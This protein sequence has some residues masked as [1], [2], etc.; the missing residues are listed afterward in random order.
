MGVSLARARPAGWRAEQGRPRCWWPWRRRRRG[1]PSGRRCRG[2]PARPARPP[3]P[4]PAR[5]PPRPRRAPAE[6]STVAVPAYGVEATRPP[7]P[8]RAPPPRPAGSARTTPSAPGTPRRST[9]RRVRI[10]R[11]RP[12]VPGDRVHDVPED[13]DDGGDEDDREDPQ[14]G[15]GTARPPDR[16]HRR[17]APVGRC[18]RRNRRRR[19]RASEASTSSTTDP[20]TTRAHA[21]STGSASSLQSRP[22]RRLDG[23]RGGRE[24]PD[25][26][27]GAQH[28]VAGVR[29]PPASHGPHPTATGPAVR[30]SGSVTVAPQSARRACTRPPDS[31]VS[32]STVPGRPV[33]GGVG[34]RWAE[35][36]RSG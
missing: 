25:D 30:L 3:P 9:V 16:R 20:A 10:D 35:R 34:D 21:T 12:D 2:R 8:R 19:D 13:G 26:R 22:C 17:S 31:T 27:D 1:S 36:V 15:G 18:R 33:G 24:Q 6:P 4:W 7:P 29:R 14:P 5:R 23:Q 32:E 28:H 11:D